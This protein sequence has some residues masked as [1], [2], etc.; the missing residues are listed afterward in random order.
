MY[1]YVYMYVCLSVC[2]YVCMYRY[3]YIYIYSH[4]EIFCAY[5]CMHASIVVCIYTYVYVD[6][7]ITILYI[8]RI[9]YDPCWTKSVSSSYGYSGHIQLMYTCLK[10][11]ACFHDDVCE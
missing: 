8:H 6:M 3:M 7:Q 9:T 2:M 11:H 10:V 5:V 4:S 1:T